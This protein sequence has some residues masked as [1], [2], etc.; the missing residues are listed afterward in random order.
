MNFVAEAN[1][2]GERGIVDGTTLNIGGINVKFNTGGA[3]AYFDSSTPS[4]V[5]NG[6]SGLGV[7]SVRLTAT[8]QCSNSADDNIQF[9]EAVTLSFDSAMTLS[10][11]LFNADGHFALTNAFDTLMFGVNGGGLVAYNFAD[12]MT[13]T[14]NNVTTATFAFG[15]EKG[16][17]Y[18][19][20]AA[21]V[22]SAVPLPAGGLCCTNPVRDSSCESSVVAGRHEQTHTPRL[23]D[24][25]LA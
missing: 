7:C 16:R 17:Q 15:G 19:V 1:T 9:G 13:K 20:S 4:E 2:N 21:T 18:Y 14:F 22:T 12:L 10:G 3:S 5:A 8:K 23:Q 6:G 11:L 25:E 24:P